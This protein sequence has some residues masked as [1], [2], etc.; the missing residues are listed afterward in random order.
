MT[1]LHKRILVAVAGLVVIGLAVAWLSGSFEE[2]IAPGEAPAAVAAKGAT[3]GITVRRI[4]RD[5]A[6][7]AS[8]TIE[9]ARRTAVASRILARI[10][11]IQVRAGAQVSAGDELVVLDAREAGARAR[12]A[13]EALRAARSQRD[14]AAKEKTRIE[15]LVRRGAATRQRLDQAVSALRVAE[16]E[17][18]RLEQALAEARTALSHTVI[19]APVGGRVVDRLADPGDT[20]VPGQTLLR[21]YDPTALRVEVPVR[22][23]L[24]VR[25]SLGQTITVEIPALGET[26]KGAIDEIVPFAE[27]GARTLLVKI[28]LPQDP[29][30][31]AG[32]YARAAFPAGRETVLAIPAELVQRIGQLEFVAVVGP[33]GA[34]ERRAVTTGQDLGAGLVEALSGLSEGET[35]VK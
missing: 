21:I 18:E 23:T 35:L 19:R 20:A 17:T 34:Q 13:E 14:L 4:E 28:R 33:D 32:M 31:F 16:A 27:T 22:E 9:S 6:E 15:E 26:A 25:L 3:A 1:Q 30:L 12:Q 5:A 2:R 10:E 11:T 7:W 24:A 8:G 29:R